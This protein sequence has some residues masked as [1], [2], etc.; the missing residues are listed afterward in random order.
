MLPGPKANACDRSEFQQFQ[1][2]FQL[3]GPLLHSTLDEA[4][5]VALRV[6]IHSAPYKSISAGSIA[7]PRNRRR[8]PGRLGNPNRTGECLVLSECP[9][10]AS[11]FFEFHC[12]GSKFSV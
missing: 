10:G 6:T 7:V 2:Q 11:L 5:I 4:L 9:R 12:A 8:P 3:D 1:F